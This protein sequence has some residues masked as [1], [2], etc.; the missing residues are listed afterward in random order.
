MQTFILHYNIISV[1][2]ALD[3]V[4]LSVFM[5]SG[6]CRLCNTVENGGNWSNFWRIYII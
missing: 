3:G 2:I 5:A 4:L 1:Q 6:T